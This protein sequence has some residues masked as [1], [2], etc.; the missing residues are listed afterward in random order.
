M[1]LKPL[2]TTQNP[3]WRRNHLNR[4]CTRNLLDFWYLK[5]DAS[6]KTKNV[7]CPSCTFNRSCCIARGTLPC[8]SSS[9]ITIVD[10]P[11]TKLKQEICENRNCKSIKYIIYKMNI[12]FKS[13]LCWRVGCDSF[14]PYRESFYSF[15]ALLQELVSKVLR[16]EVSAKSCHFTGNSPMFFTSTS[17][18]KRISD[19]FSFSRLQAQKYFF[20]KNRI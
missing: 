8:P 16:T 18:T 9:R 11:S 20:E 3:E 2:S 1:I 17:A 15:W 14:D 7:C 13:M 4:I 12:I 6:A 5:T 19:G 10:V